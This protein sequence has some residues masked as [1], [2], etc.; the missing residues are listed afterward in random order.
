[1][2]IAHGALQIPCVNFWFLVCRRIQ[3][4]CPR[5][6]ANP[7]SNF[8]F[9]LERLVRRSISLVCKTASLVLA[10]STCF[11]IGQ[12]ADAT[13]LPGPMKRQPTPTLPPMPSQPISI[14]GDESFAQIENEIRLQPNDASRIEVAIAASQFLAQIGSTLNADQMDQLLALASTNE[15]RNEMLIQFRTP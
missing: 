13:P 8:Q 5:E 15:A 1:M 2:S 3:V 10:L 7:F 12:T 4:G 9:S 11:V 6:E 14:V